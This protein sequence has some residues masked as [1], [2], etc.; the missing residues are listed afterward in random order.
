M[1]ELTKQF[2]SEFAVRPFL[3]Q[4]PSEALKRLSAWTQ[5]ESEHVRRFVSEGTRLYLPWGE[6]IL[7]FKERVQTL[8]LLEKLKNDTSLYVRKS[9]ANHLNDFSRDHASLLISVLKKWDKEVAK[10]QRENFLWIKKQALRTLIKKGHE[11]ALKLMGVKNKFPKE[12]VKVKFSSKKI[13]LGES[14]ELHLELT[15]TEKQKEI[16][17]VDFVLGFKRLNKKFSSKVFKGKTLTIHPGEKI[18]FSKKLP[19]KPVS[20]RSYYKGEQKLSVQINGQSCYETSW[21]L[22]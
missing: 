13:S 17:I 19:M 11:D 10:E 6:K 15:S 2:T 1:Y 5:D 22:D 21:Y 4:N 8:P 7:F 18:S 12:N 20:T 16:L 9:V 3:N 14:L